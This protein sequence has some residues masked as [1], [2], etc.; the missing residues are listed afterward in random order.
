MYFYSQQE[1]CKI[2]NTAKKAIKYVRKMC[3]NTFQSKLWHDFE[4]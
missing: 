1:G 4:Q 3:Q 2:I